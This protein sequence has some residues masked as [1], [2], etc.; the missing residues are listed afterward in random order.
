MDYLLFVDDDA[1]FLRINRTYFEKRGYTVF[2]AVNRA[3]L[4]HVLHSQP[5]DCIILDI[6]IPGEGNDGYSLCRLVKQ[7]SAAP[8][9]FLSS[10]TEKDFIYRGFNLGAEDYITKPYDLKE[11]ELRIRARIAQQRGVQRHADTISYSP[12]AIDI[13]ARKALVRG[14]PISLTAHEFDI[15]LLLARSPRTVYSLESIYREIWKLPDLNNAQTVRVHLARMRHKL[16]QACP[17]YRF[18]HV[19]WGKGFLFEQKKKETD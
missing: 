1:S 2:T 8:V 7:T 10:L 9:I 17:E 18:I 16:E 12:L 15:L 5:V 19:V 13:G 4:E 3:E 14:T 11:L 6:M